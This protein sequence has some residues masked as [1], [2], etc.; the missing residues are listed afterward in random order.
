[1]SKSEE[2]HGRGRETT[3]EVTDRNTSGKHEAP[4][5]VQPVETEDPRHVGG[6]H[7]DQQESLK[8]N[9][10]G[11]QAE[12]HPDTPA[13]QHATGSFTEEPAENKK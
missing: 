3:G 8:H 12:R 10:Q 4:T 6:G 1:M 9:V 2:P 5:G 13:G 7:A 11:G